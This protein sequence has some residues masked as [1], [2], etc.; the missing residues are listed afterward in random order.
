MPLY[1]ALVWSHLAY[2][3][4]FWLPHLKKGI[5][6]LRKVIIITELK[7]L[8]YKVLKHLEHLSLGDVTGVYKIMH[9]I[10]QVNN[11]FSVF[12]IRT[13]NGLEKLIAMRCGDDQWLREI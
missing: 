11:V 10:E 6:E 9:G 5:K 7:C 1:K 8:P 2:Y 13:H 4:Q 12:H 3:N